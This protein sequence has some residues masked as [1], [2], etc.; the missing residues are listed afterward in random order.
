M[1]VLMEIP[2][3][4]PIAAP[5][6]DSLQPD[7]FT[8]LGIV[9]FRYLDK[10]ALKAH[11]FSCNAVSCARQSSPWRR[12]EY[13]RARDLAEEVDRVF[14]ALPSDDVQTITWA[15][16]SDDVRRLTHLAENPL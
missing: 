5:L 2:H 3:Q 9:V 15:E 4:Q 10:Y 13:A 6:D 14:V 11:A 8:L 12:T 7:V 1:S 16:I